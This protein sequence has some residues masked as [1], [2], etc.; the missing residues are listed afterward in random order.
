MPE[1]GFAAITLDDVLD[2]MRVVVNVSQFTDTMS[3]GHIHCCNAVPWQGAASVIP[4]V[5]KF[6]QFPFGVIY[7]SYDDTMDLTVRSDAIRRLEL[8]VFHRAH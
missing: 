8:G 3:I 1:S 5:P 4:T 7:R 6:L 2:T